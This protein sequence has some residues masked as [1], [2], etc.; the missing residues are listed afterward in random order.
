MGKRCAQSAWSGIL[1]LAL[2]LAFTLS[3]LPYG[4]AYAD[5]PSPDTIEI[6]AARVFRHMLEAND[7]LLIARYNVSYANSTSQPP[8]PIDQTFSFIWHNSNSTAISNTTAYAFHNMGYG[9]GAISFY[10][11]ANSTNTTWGDLGNVTARGTSLFDPPAPEANY[12]L[13]S[14]DYSPY[15]SPA[16]IREDLRQYIVAN[17]MFLE[18]DWNQFWANLGMERQVDLL[19]QI[20]QTDYAVLSPSGEG[21]WVNTIDNLRD[22]CPL[23][24]AL[25]IIEPTYIDE[26]H[27]GTQ[28]ET[29]RQC[30]AGTPVEDFK[31]GLSDFFGG[32]GI[33]TVCTILTVIFVMC[34]AGFYTFK[35]QKPIIGLLG[36]MPGV[37]ILT[38]MGFPEMAIILLATAI[39]VLTFVVSFFWKPGV[40]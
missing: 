32:I 6:E 38:I 22:I 4:V 16:D 21:Y 28:A 33:G 24:F 2:C 34:V 36:A 18:L 23:L 3:L 30:Y 37:L 27:P 12:T 11:A 9:K 29:Y 7:T 1:A 8:Q 15:N 17:S 19:M 10:L 39:A 40:G 25:Q 13:Q 20:P 26:E 35:W 31:E 5:L 14:G